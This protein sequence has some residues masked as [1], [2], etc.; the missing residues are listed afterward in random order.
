MEPKRSLMVTV[1]VVVVAIWTGILL[2]GCASTGDPKDA[3]L[4]MQS[5]P[6]VDEATIAHKETSGSLPEVQRSG[7]IPEVPQQPVVKTGSSGER[8][9]V[10]EANPRTDEN[11]FGQ[12]AANLGPTLQRILPEALRGLD[13]NRIVT[14]L[15]GIVAMALVW[16]LALWLARLPR[17]RHRAGRGAGRRQVAGHAR[18]PVTQ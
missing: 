8:L 17:R 3:G 5:P 6:P 1:L 14:V 13:W 12:L 15:G 16:G 7:S 4:G 10:E 9:H 11:R 2:G 18:V